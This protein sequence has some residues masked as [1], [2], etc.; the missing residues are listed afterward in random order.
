M[1]RPVILLAV[2]PL[3]AFTAGCND[4]C[5]GLRCAPCEPYA[6]VTVTV[7]GA[8][9]GSEVSTDEPLLCNQVMDGVTLCNGYPNADEV[10]VNADDFESATVTLDR[11]PISPSTGGCCPC[12]IDYRLEGEVTLRAGTPDGGVPGDA[13]P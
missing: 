11:I 13:A 3:L 10:T 6:T 8:P 9:D 1:H 12:D 4:D 2:A 5:A 7:T